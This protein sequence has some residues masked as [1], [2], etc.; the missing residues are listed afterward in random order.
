MIDCF[1][2]KVVSYALSNHSDQS[3]VDEMLEEALST[4]EPTECKSLVIHTDRGGH[5]RGTMWI[6]SLEGLCITRSPCQ[7]KKNSGDNT[8]CEGFFGR[9]KTEMYY[10]IVQKNYVKPTV[11]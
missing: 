4:L 8:L 9:M 5:Y 3:L 6:E 1:D 11:L 10:G 7:E 2:A